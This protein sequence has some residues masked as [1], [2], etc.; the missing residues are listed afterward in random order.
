VSSE[1]DG[2]QHA[3]NVSFG[4]QSAQEEVRTRARGIY[5]SLSSRGS[6]ERAR[7]YDGVSG[8]LTVEVP[9]KLHLTTRMVTSSLKLSPQKSAA[10]L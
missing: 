8:E 5:P 10:A 7:S 9:S 2:C 4:K 6:G 1:L 3:D